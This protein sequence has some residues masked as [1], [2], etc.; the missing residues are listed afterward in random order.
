MSRAIDAAV[1]RA[2]AR[3]AKRLAHRRGLTIEVV[4]GGIAV[5]GRGLKA[6]WL[7]DPTLR[8]LGGCL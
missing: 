7:T 8:W 2:S 6:R 4:P 3:V 1:A 5:S